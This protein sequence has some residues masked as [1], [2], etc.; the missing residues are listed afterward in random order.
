MHASLS[1]ISQTS[2][3]THSFQYCQQNGSFVV[4]F[5]FAE[6]LVGVRPGLPRIREKS[7]NLIFF[8]FQGQG[9][10]K[11]FREPSGKFENIGKCQ[12]ILREGGMRCNAIN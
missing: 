7:G 3:A 10:V 4:K 2:S 6:P 9:I 11:E 5:F 12:E 1:S 8:F